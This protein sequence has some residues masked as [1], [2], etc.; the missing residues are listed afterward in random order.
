MLH[1]L[2]LVREWLLG[3]VV[4]EMDFDL[5]TEFLANLFQGQSLGLWECE[6]QQ[7]NVDGSQNDEE[8][9]ELPSDVGERRRRSFEI[10]DCREEE[11][12]QGE[13]DTS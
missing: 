3:N 12:S 5:V 8:K 11:N 4:S 10:C 6:V 1:L 2:R 9:I 13:R 7:G